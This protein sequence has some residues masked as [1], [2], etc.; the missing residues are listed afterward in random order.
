M[1]GWDPSAE[2]RPLPPWSRIP[3]QHP[4]ARP[5]QMKEE[6]S[7]SWLCQEVRPEPEQAWWLAALPGWE[8]SG[9]PARANLQPWVQRL[10]FSRTV[11]LSLLRMA[12]S[13][14]PGVE[15][16][17]TSLLSLPAVLPWTPGLGLCAE[18]LAGKPPASHRAPA[19]LAPGGLAR[20]ALGRSGFRRDPWRVWSYCGRSDSLGKEGRW[21]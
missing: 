18:Q 10:L 7:L 2:N 19:P 11:A 5:G 4:H 14:A 9:C 21:G 15:A 1:E 3:Y 12:S 6:G 20:E 16:C 13:L 8:A 17:G